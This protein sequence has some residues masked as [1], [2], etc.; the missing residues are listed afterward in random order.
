MKKSKKRSTF[1]KPELPPTNDLVDVNTTIERLNTKL[2]E[3]KGGNYLI[4]IKEIKPFR[5]IWVTY[6]YY[7]DVIIHIVDI[8]NT[9]RETGV[10]VPGMGKK[11][12]E[13]N[14]NRKLHI[15]SFV[16]W[17]PFEEQLYE[18]ASRWQDTIN[19]EGHY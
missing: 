12:I 3:L 8:N 19:N 7:T 15:T 2:K 4:V 10:M 16:D 9:K 11:P 1:D 17:K 6:E 18:M 14:K 5:R 13:L